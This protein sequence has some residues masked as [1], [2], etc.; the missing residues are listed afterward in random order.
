MAGEYE[1]FE[2]IYLDLSRVGGRCRF[3]AS[4]MGWKPNS[5]GA[6]AKDLKDQN[7]ELWTLEAHEFI[8]AHWSRASKGYELK[9]FTRTMGIV[10]LDGFEQDVR[11]LSLITL[12]PVNGQSKLTSIAGP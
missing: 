9:V 5:K 8:Q 2:N 11:N 6:N 10:Q 4:G 3:G 12:E 1:T 7:M